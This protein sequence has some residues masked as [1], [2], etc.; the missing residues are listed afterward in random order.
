MGKIKIFSLTQSIVY[1]NIY[2]IV[3]SIWLYG[4][5]VTGFPDCILRKLD[6]IQILA[7][8]SVDIG[9]SRSA[10]FLAGDLLISRISIKIN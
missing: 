8:F 10:H 1:S 6:L 5:L 9:G 4:I 7:K 2:Y 3:N